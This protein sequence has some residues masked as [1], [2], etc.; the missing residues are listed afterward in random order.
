MTVIYLPDPSWTPDMEQTYW[1]ITNP[2]GT[3]RP[4]YH[5][6]DGVLDAINARAN[7]GGAGAS[8][9]PSAGAA[10]QAGAS[11]VASPATP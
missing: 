5:A 3:P 2:D 7:P 6:L 9:S 10:P 1:A 8:P 4:A 11:P